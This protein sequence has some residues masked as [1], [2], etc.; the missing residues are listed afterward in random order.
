[1]SEHTPLG[2]EPNLAADVFDR[3]PASP[4]MFEHLNLTSGRRRR[5]ATGKLLLHNNFLT[6]TLMQMLWLICAI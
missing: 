1:M 4:S 3:D 5:Q 6:P 2:P